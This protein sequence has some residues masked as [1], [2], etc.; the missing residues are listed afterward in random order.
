[1]KLSVYY[2]TKRNQNKEMKSVKLRKRKLANGDY[3]LF[4]DIYAG[5]IAKIDSK[6]G[7]T[8][9]SNNRLRKSLGL[10]L[11]SKPK[12]HKERQQNRDTERIAMN[13]C[14]EEEF[15]IST[16]NHTD[17]REYDSKLDFFEYFEDFI[18]AYSKKDI[19]QVRR[20]LV[21]FKE[22]LGSTRRYR[23]YKHRI[24]FDD[25][26]KSMIEGFVE[27]I[28]QKYT[29]E[30][31]HTL[32]ARFKKVVRRAYEEEYFKRNPCEGITI[33]CD[34]GQIK[35]ETLKMD[36][37]ELLA[38]THFEGENL[39][40]RRAFAFCLFTGIRWCDVRLLTYR[41]I[42]KADNILKFNQ[43]KTQG[44][45][46]N[47]QVTIPLSELLIKLLDFP[48]D[49]EGEDERLFNLPSDT[50]CNKKL[51]A[52]MEAAGIKKHITWHCA[53]HSF[54]TNLYEK[55]V[56]P[57]TI[58]KLMGHS[59]LKYTIRYAHVRDQLKREAM[60]A[61]SQNKENIDQSVHNITF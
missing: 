27:Y 46:A 16:I 31:P 6:S 12:N 8:T 38:K 39:E 42:S 36:E 4:L 18:D 17:V 51:K 59:S 60:D 41:N 35:K 9:Y 19:R 57:I 11:I 45:S 50:T 10:T 40:V 34:S 24:N 1:M 26:S 23:H 28:K 53:R 47:S 21:Q 43:L 55:N 49:K 54:G 48:A 37:I 44:T 29:G 7:K 13:M 61:L 25:I 14:K 30:G 32:F 52:W 33:P 5:T 20:A 3:S 56:N 58:M 2:N 22:Y 15:R